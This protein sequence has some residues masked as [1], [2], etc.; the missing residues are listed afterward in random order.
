MSGNEY[1][2]A[3]VN[4]P[5]QNSVGVKCVAVLAVTTSSQAF[6][7]RTLFGK[8]GEL[9]TPHWSTGFYSLEADMPANANSR[10]YVALGANSAG[11][12]SETAT[13]TGPTVCWMIPD[14]QTLPGLVL[15]GQLR[16]SGVATSIVSSFLY[17]KGLATGYLRVMRSST[18]AGVGAGAF[19]PP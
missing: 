4:L 2:A 9:E 6:N 14:G 12:I 3:A 8:A 11:S 5:L 7:L 15:G 16:S 10:I 17:V 19:P 13:G 18:P 1:H